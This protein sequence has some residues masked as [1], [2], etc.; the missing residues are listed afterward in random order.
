MMDSVFYGVPEHAHGLR[1]C[2]GIAIG[3]ETGL[4]CALA[5]FALSLFGRGWKRWTM[6]IVAAGTSCLWFSWL[7]WLVQMEC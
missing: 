2:G 4:F 7:T 6:A 3:V 1:R 5:A